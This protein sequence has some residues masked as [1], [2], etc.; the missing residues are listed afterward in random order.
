MCVEICKLCVEICKLCV[1]MCKLCV[2]MCKLCVEMCKLCVE[3][4]LSHFIFYLL[5]TLYIMLFIFKLVFNSV[6]YSF[7]N[8]NQIR[9]WIIH[10][11]NL[12][13]VIRKLLINSSKF[14]L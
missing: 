9:Y 3:I 14:V 13:F 5:C 1:E 4:C 2:E 8:I 11:C 7:I 6:D 10:Y 12:L